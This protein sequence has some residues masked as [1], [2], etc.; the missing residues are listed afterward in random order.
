MTGARRARPHGRGLQAAPI[1]S[2]YLPDMV[3]GLAIKWL[4][5]LAQKVAVSFPGA[6]AY[7]PGKAVVTGIPCGDGAG[8]PGSQGSRQKLAAA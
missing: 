5:L 1:L 2:I 7:F 3:P 8:G 6:A 4:S